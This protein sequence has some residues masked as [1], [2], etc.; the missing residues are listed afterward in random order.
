M[1]GALLWTIDGDS[2]GDRFGIAL[3]GSPDWDGDGVPDAV[4]GADP[5]N[6]SL[7]NY[8]RILSGVDGATLFGLQGDNPQDNFGGAVAG[9]G[10]I[11]GDSRND[12][13]IGASTGSPNGTASGY[14]RVYSGAIVS[15]CGDITPYCTVSPNS[16]GP[17]AVML[18]GGTVNVGD[19]DLVLLSTGCPPNQNG[20]FYYGA[21]QNSVPFGNGVRCIGGTVFRLPITATSA[22]GLASWPLNLNAAPANSGPGQITPGSTWNFQFWFR[23]PPGGGEQFNL[24]NGLEITFCP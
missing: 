15:T 23:D 13:A 24:S 21:A 12:I 6:A 1:T 9:L 7:E 19:N 20:I 2:D 10:D 5:T 17:G 18:N 11:N 4:V 22:T 3:S 14:I 8:V 16:A